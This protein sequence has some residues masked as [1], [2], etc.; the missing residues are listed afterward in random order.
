MGVLGFGWNHT[1]WSI[2][3]KISG[4]R[5]YSYVCGSFW[6]FWDLDQIRGPF[7]VT[8]DENLSAIDRSG[9]V[10]SG[11][12]WEHYW[13]CACR[14][15]PSSNFIISRILRR[16]SILYS[17][18]HAQR[19]DNHSIATITSRSLAPSRS[20][21]LH[22]FQPWTNIFRSHSAM[23]DSAS[24]PATALPA[25]DH[26]VTSKRVRFAGGHE[27]NSSSTT[28]AQQQRRYLIAW[29]LLSM[30]RMSVVIAVLQMMQRDHP[31]IRSLELL[32]FWVKASCP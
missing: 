30:A 27:S 18:L 15:P 9:S 14:F 25:N 5:T 13:P 8:W 24:T 17:N 26:S 6:E 1:Y 31:G 19:C 2:L 12:L 7:C 4:N 23:D 28:G 10:C 29:A 21:T 16:N 3:H 11:Q 20:P 32:W 22:Y